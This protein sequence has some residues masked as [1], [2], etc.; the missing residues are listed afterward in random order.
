MTRRRTS[1]TGALVAA[2]LAVAGTTVACSST[3]GGSTDGGAAPTTTATTSAPT[4]A[5][6]GTTARAT[7]TTAARRTTTTTDGSATATV[8]SDDLGGIDPAS[9]GDL[10]TRA[11]YQR[12]TTI[13][14][15]TDQ[16][17]VDVPSTWEHD[18]AIRTITEVDVPN[19]VAAPVLQDYY[20]DRSTPG[21]RLAAY[22]GE[23]ADR[24]ID[25]ALRH[26]A[27]VDHL[28]RCT[29]STETTPVSIGSRQGTAQVTTGCGR[30]T[31]VTVVQVAAADP[32]GG[33]LAVLQV[34]LVSTAD[35]AALARILGSASAP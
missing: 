25:W 4:T 17:S 35:V 3:T 8:T 18:G 14:D 24:G 29:G 28:D 30:D 31:D 33:D 22:Q 1:P 23:L 32:A 26:E 15:E 2:L 5:A 11:P 10:R 6:P 27:E 21:M 34:A 12:F 7:A 19:L 13:R 20:D 9:L 16:V